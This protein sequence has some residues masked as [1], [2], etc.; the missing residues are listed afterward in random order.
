MVAEERERATQEQRE[1]ASPQQ[2]LLGDLAVGVQEYPAALGPR[3]DQKSVEVDRRV[4]A[5]EVDPVD[6]RRRPPI[7]SDQ[8]MP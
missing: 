6:H 4:V 7:A 2:L 5:R 3:V 8:E 1:H